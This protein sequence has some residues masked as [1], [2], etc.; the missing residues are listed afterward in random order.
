MQ[1]TV[2]MTLCQNIAASSSGRKSKFPHFRER[3]RERERESEREREKKG[4]AYARMN[5][6]P[7]PRT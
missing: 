3:E 6:Q 2:C 4:R 5:M 1:E 7:V